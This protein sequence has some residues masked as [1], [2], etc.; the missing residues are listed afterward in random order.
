MAPPLPRMLLLL[1]FLRLTILSTALV[2]P[3]FLQTVR[4]FRALEVGDALIWIAAPQLLIC[5][6]AG[7]LLR[8]FDARLIATLGFMSICVACLMV[9]H[10]LTVLWGSDQ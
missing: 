6:M 10:G 4:G 7:Y 3:Q 1:S 2:I 8:R 5:F 9:A